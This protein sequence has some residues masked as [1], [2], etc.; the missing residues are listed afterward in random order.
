MVTWH[1]GSRGLAPVGHLPSAPARS[2]WGSAAA[3]GP[4]SEAPEWGQDI[5]A[6]HRL[7]VLWAAQEGDSR[8]VTSFAAGVVPRAWALELARA[9]L[10]A[11]PWLS[12]ARPWGSDVAARPPPQPGDANRSAALFLRTFLRGIPAPQDDEGDL[13]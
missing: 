8:K 6:A 7:R 4:W 2:L 1:R 3:E 10:P 5:R 13:Q 9:H 12:A 11:A